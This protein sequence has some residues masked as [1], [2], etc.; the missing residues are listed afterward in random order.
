MKYNL[1]IRNLMSFWT[2]SLFD[3]FLKLLV[4]EDRMSI[5]MLRV[6]LIYKT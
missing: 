3:F 1:V 2:F 6:W 5:T 4:L